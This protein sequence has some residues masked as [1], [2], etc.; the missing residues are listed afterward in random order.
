RTRPWGARPR[1]AF[2]AMVSCLPAMSTIPPP[3]TT[4]E[5]RAI[6]WPAPGA[7]PGGPLR[8]VEPDEDEVAGAAP[9]LAGF[10]NDPP[11]RRMMG[12]TVEMTAGDVIEHWADARARGDRAFLL[13]AGDVLVGDADLRRI[14]G[15]RAEFAFLVAVG[16]GRGLGT[17][18]GVML[19][20][21]AFRV[22]S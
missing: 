12:N 15:G 16:P 13:Y 22:L 21:F 6:E 3:A 14:G 19:A 7:G 4:T 1:V 8:A 11:N 20:A 5:R 2:D 17:R 18:F 9:A 10:Y